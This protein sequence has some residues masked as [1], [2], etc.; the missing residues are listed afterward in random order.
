MRRLR[1]VGPIEEQ[2]D[3]LTRVQAVARRWP[4]AAAVLV[5]GLLAIVVLRPAWGVKE[6]EAAH[7]LLNAPAAGPRA[8]PPTP[9]EKTN[10]SSNRRRWRRWQP[11]K[12]S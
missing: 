2:P 7:I 11:A 8:R 1:P 5:S 9:P 3:H 4:A 12:E 10:S 6:Y